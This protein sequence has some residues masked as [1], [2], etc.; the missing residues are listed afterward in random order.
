MTSPVITQK[1]IPATSRGASITGMT[2]PVLVAFVGPAQRQAIYAG[3]RGEEREY[4]AETL[5]TLAER[6]NS[7][8]ATYGQD[9]ASDPIA[10]LHYFTGSCDWHIT[11]KDCDAD[12]EGQRQAFGLANLGHGGEL[13]YI[14]L[15]E[16]AR[17]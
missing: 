12:G 5:R 11:E 2:Y 8:P 14:D 16:I 17:C 1:R 9:G 13:G 7:M 10:Y 6:I 15:A 4:F 3:L